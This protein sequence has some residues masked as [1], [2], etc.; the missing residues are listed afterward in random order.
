[1]SLKLANIYT[2]Y[3]NKI[4]KLTTFQYL[5]PW[6]RSK[7]RS[8]FINSIMSSHF[9]WDGNT[10]NQL[11]LMWTSFDTDTQSYKIQSQTKNLELI[12][13]KC[14]DQHNKP[15]QPNKLHTYIFRFVVGINKPSQITITVTL[16]TWP[17]S[18][19]TKSLS[20]HVRYD[21]SMSKITF[22]ESSSITGNAWKR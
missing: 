20:S 2:K 21:K 7:G 10:T 17:S 9:A 22:T 16:R 11:I 15:N 1:M 6:I 12:W 19:Q 3:S 18:R 13:R 5:I 8:H 14:K 4:S